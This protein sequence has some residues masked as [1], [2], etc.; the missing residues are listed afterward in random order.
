M[1]LR[2]FV[3][4]FMILLQVQLNNNFVGLEMTWLYMIDDNETDTL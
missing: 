4:K 3:E 1:K 2:V